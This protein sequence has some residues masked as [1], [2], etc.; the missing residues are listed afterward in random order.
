VLP[1]AIESAAGRHHRWT[2]AATK[3]AGA[4]QRRIHIFL[5]VNMSLAAS[6]YEPARTCGEPVVAGHL[7]QAPAVTPADHRRVTDPKRHISA[8]SGD[9]VWFQPATFGL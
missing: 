8:G 6:D 4:S 5:A 9:S 3:P 1:P 7:H 2:E